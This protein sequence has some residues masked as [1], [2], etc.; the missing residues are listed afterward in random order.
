M[1]FQTVC[2]HIAGLE[3]LCHAFLFLKM[4]EFISFWDRTQ[5]IMMAMILKIQIAA[6]GV[7]S[8]AI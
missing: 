2:Q 8:T 1:Y 3:L 7:S 6:V 4:E 5:I